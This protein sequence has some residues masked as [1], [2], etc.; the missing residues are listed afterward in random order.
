MSITLQ[1]MA[2]QLGLRVDGDPVS[3]CISGWSEYYNQQTIEN[4]C[5]DL[6]GHVP[7]ERDRQRGKWNVNLS[8]FERTVC[9]DLGDDPTHQ[10]LL[11]HTRDLEECGRLS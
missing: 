1:D 9:R 10:Q 8:W 2:Y 11:Q 4:I 6:L 5:L 7:T 3:G